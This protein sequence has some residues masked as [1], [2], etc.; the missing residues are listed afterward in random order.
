VLDHDHVGGQLLFC[1]S[2]LWIWR[3]AF[4][5]GVIDLDYHDHVPWRNQ[6]HCEVVNK[7]AVIIVGVFVSEWKPVGVYG[8]VEKCAES[9]VGESWDIGGRG[10]PDLHV[11]FFRHGVE[12]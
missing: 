11:E 8:G 5:L 12:L 7:P 6:T 9:D 4:V 3:V 2:S 10:S 1:L